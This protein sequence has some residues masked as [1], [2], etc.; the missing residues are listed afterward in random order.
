MANIHI[1]PLI[2]L[3]LISLREIDALSI[4]RVKF[5]DF[6]GFR[7][8]NIFRGS[9]KNENISASISSAIPK[10]RTNRLHVLPIDRLEVRML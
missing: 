5:S 8:I 10:R 2:I 4:F 9:I 3:L 1:V 6:T 7:S